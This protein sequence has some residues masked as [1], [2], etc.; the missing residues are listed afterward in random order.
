MVT[1]LEVLPLNILPDS[2][3]VSK[4]ALELPQGL[5]FQVNGILDELSLTL[6]FL[7]EFGVIF[8]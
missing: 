5:G 7:D 4:G 1:L 2:L 3:G 8:V 6:R